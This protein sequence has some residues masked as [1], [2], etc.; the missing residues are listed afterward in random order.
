M[1]LIQAIKRKIRIFLS[2]FYSPEKQFEIQMQ[3]VID[4][5]DFPEHKECKYCGINLTDSES[6]WTTFDGSYTCM[7]CDEALNE[8]VNEGKASYCLTAIYPTDDIEAELN[9]CR[10]CNHKEQCERNYTETLERFKAV[11]NAARNKN[12]GGKE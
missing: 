8:A 5:V 12:N 1:K 11:S 9:M 2:P 4:K 6:F 10:R 7:S 3:D